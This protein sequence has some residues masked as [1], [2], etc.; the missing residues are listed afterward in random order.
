[1]DKSINTMSI[2]VAKSPVLAAVVIIALVT[3]TVCGGMFT[4]LNEDLKI[5]REMAEA[6]S[7]NTKLLQDNISD[8]KSTKAALQQDVNDIWETLGKIRDK[9]VTRTYSTE[10]PPDLRQDLSALFQKMNKLS[11]RVGG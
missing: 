5:N 8:V 2:G 3:M 1:M 9:D 4:F 10:M 6:I 11:G 7:C